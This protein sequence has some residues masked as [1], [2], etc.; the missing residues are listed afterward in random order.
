MIAE[1]VFM[2][3]NS[4]S[5]SRKHELNPTGIAAMKTGA[6]PVTSHCVVS[7]STS[8]NALTNCRNTNEGATCSL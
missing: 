3:K 6:L 7:T 4:Y 5:I 1:G 2:I 8:L